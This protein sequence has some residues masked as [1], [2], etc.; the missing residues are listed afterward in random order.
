MSKPTS[1]TKAFYDA[2]FPKFERELQEALTVH[3]MNI[4]QLFEAIAIRY[5][6]IKGLAGLTF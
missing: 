2:A 3:K 1:P 6:L 5:S 4:I